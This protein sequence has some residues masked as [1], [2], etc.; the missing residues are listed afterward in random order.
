MTLPSLITQELVHQ[1]VLYAQYSLVIFKLKGLQ[2]RLYFTRR[3]STILELD[4]LRSACPLLSHICWCLYSAAGW[5]YFWASSRFCIRPYPIQVWYVVQISMSD[6]IHLDWQ[7]IP[8]SQKQF[9]YTPRGPRNIQDHRW[10][11]LNQTHS[12]MQCT[13]YH[14]QKNCYKSQTIGPIHMHTGNVDA[15]LWAVSSNGLRFSHPS[16]IVGKVVLSSRYRKSSYCASTWNLRFPTLQI[17]T[18]ELIWEP[19]WTIFWLAH[20]NNIYTQANFMPYA[21]ATH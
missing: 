16:R 12:M 17:R 4:W 9:T 2:H 6:L 13:L 5:Q 21:R 20:H 19:F 11:C 8:T 15:Y 7:P 18:F 14:H 10:N 3:C 1:I